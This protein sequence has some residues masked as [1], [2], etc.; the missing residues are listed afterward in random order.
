M[1]LTDRQ[2]REVCQEVIAHLNSLAALTHS[3]SCT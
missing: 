3:V 1:T 2:P